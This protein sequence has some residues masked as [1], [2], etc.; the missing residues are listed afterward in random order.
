MNVRSQLA[1]QVQAAG[2]MAVRT[3]ARSLPGYLDSVVINSSPEPRRFRDV[4]QPWQAEVFG[5]FDAALSDVSRVGDGYSGPRRFWFVLPRGHDKTSAIGRRLNYLLAFSRR[6]LHMATAAADSDQAGLIGEA[7]AAEA[8][9]N[10][11]LG[12]RL[13]FGRQRVYGPG[14]SL[15]I[16]SADAPSSFGL[17]CDVIIIDELTHWNQ[18]ELWDVLIS[19]AAKRRGA[20][21]AVISNAGVRGTWQWDVYQAVKA[22]PVQWS[23]FEAPEGRRLATWMSEEQVLSDRKLL[24]P[25]LARRVYDN[26]WIDPG[27]ES[28][29]LARADV[30]ACERLGVELGLIRTQEGRYGVDYVAGID[31][32][33]KRDR[34]ALCVVHHAYDKRIRVDDF[35]TLQGNPQDPVTV[36]TVERWM[37]D[38]ARRFHRPLFVVDPYQLEGTIQRYEHHHLIERFEPRGG[39]SNYEMAATLRSLVVNQ[40]LVWYPGAGELLVSRDGRTFVE[41]F[42]DE[43]CGLI[44]RPMTYGYRFDHESKFHDDRSVAVGMAALYAARNPPAPEWIP[45]PDL[46]QKAKGFTLPELRPVSS[47]RNLWGIRR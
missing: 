38:I 7:M 28:G 29:F 20:V 2:E 31:Y 40:R 6:N 19:G 12:D 10:P 1:L 17:N 33:P 37:D 8:K 41:T 43:L 4:K 24:P 22:D 46:P 14:G 16:L 44:I 21:I 47:S 25:G 23:V 13:K 39:K 42:A 26:V 3:S 11:W 34:T 32:G 30:E 5:G 18:R 35:V 36:E 45:P 27:E 15:K 9:L